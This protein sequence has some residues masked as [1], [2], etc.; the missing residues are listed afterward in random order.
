MCAPAVEVHDLPDN[1]R[2]VVVGGVDHL[3]VQDNGDV[4]LGGD[5]GV[6][7]CIDGTVKLGGGEDDREGRVWID[8]ENKI[9]VGGQAGLTIS[10]GRWSLRRAVRRAF[11]P[12]VT[13][14]VVGALCYVLYSNK[15]GGSGK[16][17]A[18]TAPAGTAPPAPSAS[19]STSSRLQWSRF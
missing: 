13:G 2:R 1:R 16:A 7:V 14:M 5:R 8:A 6:R 19:A 4:Q 18:G 9:I 10:P 12:F 3:V 11:K 15:A 17:P